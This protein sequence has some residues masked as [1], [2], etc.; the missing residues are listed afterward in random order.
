M[1]ESCHKHIQLYAATEKNLKG[2]EVVGPRFLMFGT[3]VVE[4]SG[5]CQLRCELCAVTR[6][7]HRDSLVCVCD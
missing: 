6:S 2:G 7:I 1:N 5:V 4:T 3:P